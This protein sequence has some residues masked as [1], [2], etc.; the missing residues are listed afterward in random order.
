MASLGSVLP[1]FENSTL[2]FTSCAVVPPCSFALTSAET[3]SCP[4]ALG[5]Y[6]LV[7]PSDIDQ[8]SS[9]LSRACLVFYPGGND[10][11]SHRLGFLFDAR[12]GQSFLT[13]RHGK[14]N[15]MTVVIPCDNAK[16]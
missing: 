1:W 13:N 4:Q 2:A 5:D 8:N 7:T 9:T 16:E 12:T 14:R 11:S 10:D 15:N 3:A 6:V